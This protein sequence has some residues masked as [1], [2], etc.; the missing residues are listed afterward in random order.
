MNILH[1]NIKTT[2]TTSLPL[3]SRHSFPCSRL[4]PH[5]PPQF[6]P[7]KLI[8]TSGFLTRCLLCI[9][10]LS[11]IYGHSDALYHLNVNSNA[12]SFQPVWTTL[13]S[14]PTAPFCD[15]FLTVINQSEQATQ[16]ARFLNDVISI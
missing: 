9:V 1:S 2:Y 15:I 6:I 7:C 5:K 11:K 12:T 4:S 8:P 16:S 13:N 3:S 14:L 10:P